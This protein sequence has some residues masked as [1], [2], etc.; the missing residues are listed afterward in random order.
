MSKN[1]GRIVEASIS[2]EL[3]A[4]PGIESQENPAVFD[5]VPD[6]FDVEKF[7]EG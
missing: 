5:A 3:R 6:R 2:A 7:P 1:C 4:G